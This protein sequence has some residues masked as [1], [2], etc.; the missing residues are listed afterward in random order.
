V[1]PVTAAEIVLD[2]S[3]LVRGVL[4]ESDDATQIV[5]SIAGGSLRAH[6][7]DLIGP[8]T[9]NALV[10]LV[11]AG[12]STPGA[13]ATMLEAAASSAIVRHPS[14]RFTR[15]AFE[16][17]VATGISAYDAFYAVLSELLELPLVTADRKLA[18]AVPNVI[19]VG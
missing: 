3:A 16:L 2:A 14:A 13:A 12:R 1:K 5:A 17:A 18:A 19:L 11:R 7:P 15:P 9:A 6:A 4:R 10:R 8:E